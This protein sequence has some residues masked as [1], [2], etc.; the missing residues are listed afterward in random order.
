DK[1][2]AKVV[3]AVDD[4]PGLKVTNWI[5][6]GNDVLAI[7]SLLSGGKVDARLFPTKIGGGREK[8]RLY[9]ELE[10]GAKLSKRGPQ[11]SLSNG[12]LKE[13]DGWSLRMGGFGG[14]MGGHVEEAACLTDADGVQYGGKAINEFTFAFDGKGKAVGVELAGL[15]VKLTK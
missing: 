9:F 12:I 5:N 11:I 15:R 8:W 10:A 7:L 2:Q 1:G 4:G 3:L 13:M 6:R 14:G